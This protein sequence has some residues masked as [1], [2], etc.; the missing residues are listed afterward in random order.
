MSKKKAGK[1]KRARGPAR[2]KT[3]GIRFTPEEL[4]ELK[5]LADV[6]RMPMS[7]YV[8]TTLLPKKAPTT[9]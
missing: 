8:R 4:R 1:Q 5:T 3:L 2:G 9:A 6:A 7:V